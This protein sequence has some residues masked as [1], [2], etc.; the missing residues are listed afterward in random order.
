V[1][2]SNAQERGDEDPLK[3][4][5]SLEELS[6]ISQTELEQRRIPNP[7]GRVS[8]VP[9]ARTIRYYTSLGLVDRPMGYEGGVAMYGQRHL[10]QLLAIKVL[11][12]EYLPLPEI[13][14]QLFGRGEDDLKEIID[15]ATRAEPAPAS[16]PKPRLETWTT[17]RILPGLRLL[18]EDRQALLDWA[19]HHGQQS[20]HTAIEEAL[21]DLLG[22]A[23]KASEP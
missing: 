12:A 9:S 18:V 10:L 22:S 1:T 23:W 2:D 8:Q 6:Q 11:Q 14:K 17:R 7:G 15:S 4:L 16:A 19:R 3:K 20:A 21:S 13:Q 5:W